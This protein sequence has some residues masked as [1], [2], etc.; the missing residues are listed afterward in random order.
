MR[1]VEFK[2]HEFT[3]DERCMKSYKWQKAMNSG[4]AERSSRAIARLFAGR[5]EE[6]ADV[7]SENDDPDELD[8]AMDAMAE[9][10]GAVLEDMGQSAKN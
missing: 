8:S 3:Y 5:D 4:D 2:G 9:L 7:L 1:T 10:L 6:Y